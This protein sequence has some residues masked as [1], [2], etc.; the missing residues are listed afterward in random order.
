MTTSEVA[1]LLGKVHK[2]HFVGIGGIS[3]RALAEIMSIRG[4]IVTGS[5]RNEGEGVDRLRSR[6]IPVAIGHNAA[7]VGDAELVVY[8]AAV[9]ADNPELIESRGRGIPTAERAPFLGAIMPGYADRIAVSGTHGKTTVT[10]MVSHILLA[11]ELDPTILVGGNLP[12]IGGTFRIG[13][14]SY[15]VFEADE[16][17]GSFLNFLP[18]IAI[19][20]NVDADHLDYYKDLDAIKENFRRFMQLTGPDGAVV[21][22]ADD[23]NTMSCADAVPGR[24]V[25]YGIDADADYKAVITGTEG[26]FY[27]FDLYEKGELLG[28][29]RLSVPGRHNALN[30]TGAAAAAR[31]AGVS[32]EAIAKG[33]L[34]FTG[35]NRRLQKKGD[36]FGFTVMDDYAHHPTEIRSSLQ[37]A[38][39]MGYGRVWC[40]CQPHTYT[41]A[42]AL[43]NDFAD[44]LTL[45]DQAVL[46]DIYAAREPFDPS[47]SSEQ[48]A[49][50]VPGAAYCG[51]LELAEQ[52]IR[53]HAQPGELVI[54]MGAGDV[55]KVGEA[56]LA[57]AE[58]SE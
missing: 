29:I 18:K 11:A 43:F 28:N 57:E 44:A 12:A 42:K 26:G 23:G 22:C 24:R 10:S 48:L 49:A 3:M 7:N 37:A 47:V 21:L 19:V 31:V 9:K 20:L 16:Y 45:A 15:L 39:G 56:L 32:F 6:G 14:S 52:Y 1:S 36:A 58:K 5:D 50:A 13:H 4:Y 30:A 55:Y 38:T 53:E 46:V 51:S 25:T 27:A 34:E 2:I 8:T 54:T 17:V 41:R 33:L 35:T 40:V